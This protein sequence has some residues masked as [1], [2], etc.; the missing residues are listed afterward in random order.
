MK[1]HNHECP[2][3][4]VA[5]NLQ[6]AS[7]TR[8]CVRRMRKRRPLTWSKWQQL[9]RLFHIFPKIVIFFHFF[10]DERSEQRTLTLPREGLLSLRR[11]A[12]WAASVNVS[13]F[14][15]SSFST[16]QTFVFMCSLFQTVFFCRRRKRGLVRPRNRSRSPCVL[17]LGSES[18]CPETIKDSCLSF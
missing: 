7:R 8:S 15:P 13:C 14:P 16:Q 12:R 5:H 18:Q 11:L 17:H 4:F 6:D 10:F 1:T 9:S 3:I 2:L